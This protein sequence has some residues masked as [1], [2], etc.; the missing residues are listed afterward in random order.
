M[1]DY[2]LFGGFGNRLTD[3]R[4]NEWKLAVVE[5]LSRLKIP[6]KVHYLGNEQE[7]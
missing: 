7:F 1:I 6:L 4:T 3:G 2:K 5:S